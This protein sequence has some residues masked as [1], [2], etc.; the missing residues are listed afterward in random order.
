MYFCTSF[1]MSR[2]TTSSCWPSS[3][4]AGSTFFV[5]LLGMLSTPNEEPIN[6]P[7]LRGPGSWYRRR[8]ASSRN[9]KSKGVMVLVG[10]L[11]F[12][13]WAMLV[14]SF[15]YNS[16]RVLDTFYSKSFCFSCSDISWLFSFSSFCCSCSLFARCL[17]I[18]FLRWFRRFFSS[19]L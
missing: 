11:D 7:S 9:S 5:G 2:L 17:A 15:D 12:K 18:S 19:S 4:V 16:N 8:V 6:F 13:L 1:S 10:S 14:L 3:M